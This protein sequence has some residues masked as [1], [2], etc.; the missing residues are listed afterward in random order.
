MPDG[1]SLEGVKMNFSVR[2][3]IGMLASLG[4][5]AAI[6]MASPSVAFADPTGMPH[7]STSTTYAAPAQHLQ[8]T[9]RLDQGVGG[10]IGGRRIRRAEAAIL[11][12]H[13]GHLLGTS[14]ITY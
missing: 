5:G 6:V 1:A 14:R 9:F 3:L 10:P 8:A 2:R 11:V 4:I 12:T 13:T 7:I